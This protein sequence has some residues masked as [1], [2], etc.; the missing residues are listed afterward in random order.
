MSTYIGSVLVGPLQREMVEQI[1]SSKVGSGLGDE[2][3]SLHLRVPGRGGVDGH[4]ETAL[5][6]GVSWVLV[7][8]A[9]VQVAGGGLASMD[10][11]PPNKVQ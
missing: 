10:V 6:T 8:W 9:W 5:F 2:L 1:P 11:L 3:G 7:R 4:L